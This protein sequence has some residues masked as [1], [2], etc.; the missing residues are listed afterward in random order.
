MH[1]RRKTLGAAISMA[2]AVLFVGG[3]GLT[4]PA[5]ASDHHHNRHQRD[6]RHGHPN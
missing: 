3:P 2:A 6:R 5:S 1:I 4:S